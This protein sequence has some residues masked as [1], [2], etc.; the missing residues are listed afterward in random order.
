MFSV[1]CNCA[2]ELVIESKVGCL[3]SQQWMPVAGDDH[4]LPCGAHFIIALRSF[5]SLKGQCSA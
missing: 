5:A 1:Y 3:K 2:Y 4:V